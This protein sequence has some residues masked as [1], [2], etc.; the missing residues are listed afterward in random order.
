ML[1]LYLFLF[2]LEKKNKK[3]NFPNVPH[4]KPNWLNS[5]IRI[6]NNPNYNRNLIGSDNN[7]RSII[8]QWINLINYFFTDPE[9][10]AKLNKLVYVYNSSDLSV[11][12]EFSTINCSKFYNM[13]KDTLTKYIKNGV[14][15]K[16]KIFS[17]TK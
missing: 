16:G 4:I 11:I 12:G 7:K 10:L 17:R 13:G 6:Y 3:I 2:N 1:Y 14:P 15:F 8:Y 5:P 9:G